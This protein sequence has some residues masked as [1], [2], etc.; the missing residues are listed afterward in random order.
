[1]RSGFELFGDFVV[2]GTAGI[3]PHIERGIAGA[4]VPLAQIALIFRLVALFLFVR[5]PGKRGSRWYWPFC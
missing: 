5:A 2:A 4:H 3:R 1:M